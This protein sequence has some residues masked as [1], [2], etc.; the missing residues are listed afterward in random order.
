MQ[1]SQVP[2][3]GKWESPLLWDSQRINS[4]IAFKTSQKVPTIA[5]QESLW[6]LSQRRNHKKKRRCFQ[7]NINDTAI[8]LFGGIA[9]AVLRRKCIVLMV[10]IKKQKIKQNVRRTKDNTHTHTHNIRKAQIRKTALM[11]W[12]GGYN[13]ENFKNTSRAWICVRPRTWS[14]APE[15]QKARNLSLKKLIKLTNLSF[16]WAWEGTDF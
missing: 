6:G 16:N 15:K 12:G 3:R 14:I 7:S 9:T 5:A 1:W 4:N 2:E 13:R 11:K 10:Y 8:F